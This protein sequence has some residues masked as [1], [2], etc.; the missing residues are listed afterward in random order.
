MCEPRVCQP[1]LFGCLMSVFPRKQRFDRHASNNAVCNLSQVFI[2][3]IF[4]LFSSKRKF[5]ES[6]LNTLGTSCLSVLR[7]IILPI[8]LK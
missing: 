3:T 6:I 8:I 2:L 5:F 4:L 1:A 7:A